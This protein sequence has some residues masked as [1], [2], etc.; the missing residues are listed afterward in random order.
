MRRDYIQAKEHAIKEVHEE[1]HRV[2]VKFLDTVSPALH[3][4]PDRQ[5]EA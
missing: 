2:L 1:T 5:A 3:D 4:L